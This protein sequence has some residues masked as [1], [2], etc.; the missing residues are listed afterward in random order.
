MNQASWDQLARPLRDYLR[1]CGLSDETC[2]TYLGNCATFWRWCAD[3]E[4]DARLVDRRTVRAWIAERL[5][6]VS[7]SRAHNDISG[8]RYF[9][10]WA[11]ED[12]LRS[13][14]PCEGITVK[15]RKALPTEPITWQELDA[16]L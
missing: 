9:F 16:L 8:L 3:R 12:G 4:T 2:R 14:D 5:D 10:R 6:Q 1:S 13:D 11:K 15:R 7:T